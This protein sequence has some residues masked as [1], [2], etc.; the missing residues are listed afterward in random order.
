MHLVRMKTAAIT[1]TIIAEQ[2]TSIMVPMKRPI[3]LHM[4]DMPT[5]AN[6]MALN[7]R[8]NISAVI[9]GSDSMDI[10]SMMPTRRIVSTMHTAISTVMV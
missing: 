2:G 9:I 4:R 5:E 3:R 6:I 1:I 8:K 10:S 7:R